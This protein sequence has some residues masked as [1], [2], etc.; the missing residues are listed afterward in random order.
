MGQAVAKWKKKDAHRAGQH[1]CTLSTTPVDAL[2]VGERLKAHKI[3]AEHQTQ[4]SQITFLRLN[5]TY[6]A[7]SCVQYGKGSDTIINPAAQ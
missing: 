2:A 3:L 1:G 4:F 7:S 6:A 5:S